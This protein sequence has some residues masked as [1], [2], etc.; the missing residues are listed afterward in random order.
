MAKLPTLDRTSPMGAIAAAVPH[1][2]ASHSVPFAAVLFHSAN[3]N[4]RSENGG[5]IFDHGSGGIVLLRAA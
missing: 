2:N 5:A 3:E 1:A 4:G